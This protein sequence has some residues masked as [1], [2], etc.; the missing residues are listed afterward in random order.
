MVKKHEIIYREG[1]GTSN[2]IISSGGTSDNTISSGGTSDNIISSGINISQKNYTVSAVQ[3]FGEVLYQHGK[4]QQCGNLNNK[5]ESII[6]I[7]IIIIKSVHYPHLPTFHVINIL[8]EMQRQTFFKCNSITIESS[9][10]LTLKTTFKVILAF[11]KDSKAEGGSRT[12]V[13]RESGFG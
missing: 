13:E 6:S 5:W 8:L 12:R 9:L 2:N 11:L 7:V 3:S 1:G 4:L 10:C